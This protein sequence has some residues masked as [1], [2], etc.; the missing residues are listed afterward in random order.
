M[1]AGNAA[2]DDQHVGVDGDLLDLQRLVIRHA[3]DG[4][5]RQGHGLARRL[6]PVG[7]HPRVVFADIHHLEVVRIQAARLGRFAEGVLMQQRRARRHHNPVQVVFPDVLLDQLLARIGA[8]VLVGPGHGHVGQR[9]DVLGDRLDIH[10]AGD[11]GAA[12]AD[13]EAHA[14]G[15]VFLGYDWF[16]KS[17]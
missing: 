15:F 9:A 13:V 16:H 11:V 4:G 8:H 3:L 1:D 2:A 12:M 10:H 7:V 14:D 6:S 17:S 5:A